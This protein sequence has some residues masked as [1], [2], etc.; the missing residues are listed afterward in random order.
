MY[1]G[2][3]EESRG[4]K[5]ILSFRGIQY[6]QQPVGKLRWKSPQTNLPEWKVVQF[7]LFF[8]ELK[9]PYNATQ[10]V[11]YRYAYVHLSF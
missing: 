9:S 5:R 8:H 11:E 6:A 4:G 2:T 7:T 10:S 3:I 1:W